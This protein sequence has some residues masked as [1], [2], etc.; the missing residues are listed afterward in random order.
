MRYDRGWNQVCLVGAGSMGR[1]R[2]GYRSLGNAGFFPPFYGVS[3]R[4]SQPAAGWYGTLSSRGL[5]APSPALNM[6]SR[7]Q[8]RQG[9]DLRSHVLTAQLRHLCHRRGS[10]Y[11]SILLFASLQALSK[12]P[13]YNLVP[14]LPP[15]PLV[16]SCYCLVPL[17]GSALGTSCAL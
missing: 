14:T 16:T 8:G 13:L 11:E 15:I 5:A 1:S 4:R 9:V 6:Q 12:P 17:T 10:F 2:R 3:F 7:R